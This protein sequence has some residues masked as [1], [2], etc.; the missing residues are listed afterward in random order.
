MKTTTRKP[1][2]KSNGSARTASRMGSA[3]SS[4]SRSKASAAPVKG[5]LLEEFF[6]DELKDI[7]WAE[8]H[9]VKALGK[10]A[11]EATS[12]DLKTAFEDHRAETEEQVQRLE[13]V[14]SLLDKKAQ[15]KKCEAI[16]GIVKEV[17]E[18]ISE[19]KDDTFT[20]DVALIVG[21]QKVE[22]YEIAT[23]GS[24]VQLARTLGKDDV[25]DL[26]EETLEQEKGADKTLT[27]IAEGAINQEALS[28]T[29]EDT[30]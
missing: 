22:H 15:A 9:L 10:M 27:S 6:V 13:E 30:E 16:A 20:R 18:I 19:T 7:Y 3:S 1:L 4:R 12:E 29:E 23:Y 5:G 26:L 2:F 28:E 24:L 8:K 21:G 25:A 11:K 17:E 14:F